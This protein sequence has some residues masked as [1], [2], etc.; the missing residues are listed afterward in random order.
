MTSCL[1][2][3]SCRNENLLRNVLIPSLWCLIGSD[4]SNEFNENPPC[5]WQGPWFHPKILLLLLGRNVTI[6]RNVKWFTKVCLTGVTWIFSILFRVRV[7]SVFPRPDSVSG[8]TKGYLRVGKVWTE[9][10]CKVSFRHINYKVLIKGTQR[11][12]IKV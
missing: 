6:L 7:R 9:H 4:K 5:N 12:G 11:K 8:E 10:L 1:R 3:L 2:I